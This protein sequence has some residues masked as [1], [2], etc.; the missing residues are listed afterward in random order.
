M[1]DVRDGVRRTWQESL[2]RDEMNQAYSAATLCCR[3]EAVTSHPAQWR[4]T[5]SQWKSKRKREEGACAPITWIVVGEAANEAASSYH[6]TQTMELCIMAVFRSKYNRFWL[7]EVTNHPSIKQ[8]TSVLHHA[9]LP[10]IKNSSSVPLLCAQS[11]CEPSRCKFASS[12]E[13]NVS[14]ASLL[15]QNGTSQEA[16]PCQQPAASH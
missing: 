11:L 10:N 7:D 8:G 13:A 2:A 16:S 1:K 15:T 6:N 5:M 12:P 4:Q 14:F 9:S 3:C